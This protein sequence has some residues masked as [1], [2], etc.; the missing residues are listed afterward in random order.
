MQLT[1]IA[2]LRMGF[3]TQG[4]IFVTSMEVERRL[5]LRYKSQMSHSPLP[6]NQESA[7]LLQ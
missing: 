1:T 7:A 2:Q 5:T 6:A 4:M 3:T